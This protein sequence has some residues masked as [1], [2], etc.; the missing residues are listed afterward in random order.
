M[1]H[2]SLNYFTLKRCICQKY[3][4]FIKGNFANNSILGLFLV[5]VLLVAVRGKTLSTAWCVFTCVD[6]Y[7][8][9]FCSLRIKSILVI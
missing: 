8:F 2:Y 5:N 7:S 1:M 4:F 3:C 9:R 6:Y